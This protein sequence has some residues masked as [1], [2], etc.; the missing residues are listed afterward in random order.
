MIDENERRIFGSEG[1][2]R[3]DPKPEY[4]GK[5]VGEIAKL[6]N[7]D[8][9]TTLMDL[10][11]QAGA[12]GARENVVGTSM[13]EDDIRRILKWPFADIC[14][15]GE[16]SG[17]HP[18]GFGAFPRVLAHYVGEGNV[19]PLPEAIRRMTSLAASNMGLSRRGTIAAGN[20]ADLV[21]L[22]PASVA[23]HATLENPHAVSTGIDT[24]WV[25][26][27]VVFAAGKTTGK[28]PGRVLRRGMP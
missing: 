28:H 13:T 10:I 26:G 11:T 3:Y 25:N 14:T 16:L 12:D 9:A 27:Q 21:L 19:I 8:P 15:D 23:D 6:R 5:T 20:W 7:E 1:L 4:A 17:A 22:D 2:V 24:V 18:R